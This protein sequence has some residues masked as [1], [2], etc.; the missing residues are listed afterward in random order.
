MSGGGSGVGETKSQPIGSSISS[1]PSVVNFNVATCV[2]FACTV[3]RSGTE[4]S[5]E[6]PLRPIFGSWRAPGR[7][8]RLNEVTPRRQ[9]STDSQRQ[10]NTNLRTWFSVPEDRRVESCI[11]HTRFPVQISVLLRHIAHGSNLPRRNSS[12]CKPFPSSSNGSMGRWERPHRTAREE[13]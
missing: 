9:I 12:I 11:F 2:A 7:R 10:T 8:L 1:C 4:K 13:C 3:R 6:S 5:D